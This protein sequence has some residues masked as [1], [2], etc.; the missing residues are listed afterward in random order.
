MYSSDGIH[1]RSFGGEGEEN[2]ELNQPS[3]IAFGNHGNIIVADCNNDRVQVFDRNGKF[4]RKF[5]KH[6]TLDHK[7]RNPEGLSIN[8]HGYIIVSDRDNKLIKIFSSN[9]EYLGK[10]GGAGSLVSPYHCI[11]HGQYL[12]VSDCDDHSIKNQVSQLTA[13]QSNSENLITKLGHEDYHI[14]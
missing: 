13:H 9:G 11:Q 5:G 10:F 2:G 7:L 6:G 8:G 12:I 1:L 3:G 14:R 4:F